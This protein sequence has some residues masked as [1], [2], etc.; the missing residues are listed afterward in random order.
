MA[1]K[2]TD[3]TQ[4]LHL[5]TIAMAHQM[6]LTHTDISA[7]SVCAGSAMSLACG[8]MNRNT[9]HML[10]RWHSDAMLQYL[11]LQAKHLMH[12]FTVT[13]FNHGSYSFIPT[14]TIPSG[15]Y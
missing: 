3:I 13:L 2:A 9:I 7:R 10:G 14:D 1:I 11:H 12:K 6:G 5:A 15:N 8:S 4:A